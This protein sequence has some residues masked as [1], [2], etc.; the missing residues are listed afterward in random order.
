MNYADWSQWYDLF[1]STE[2]GEEVDFY[3]EEAIAANGP[4]L[5]IGVG[6]GRIAIPIA[7]RHIEVFGVDMS[8]EML[9]VA[10]AKASA[11]SPLTGS[12]TLAQADMRTLRLA[13]NDFALVAIPARTL[14]LATT[15]EDQV[16]TLCSAAR[17]LRPGGKLILNVF[18]PTPDLIFDDSGE[19]VL[20]GEVVDATTGKTFQLSAINRFDPE[21]QIN[22][23]TQIVEEVQVDG[24][25]MVVAELPVTLRYLFPHE[26]FSLLEETNLQVEAVYGWFDRSP[27]D[28]ECDEIIF[29]ATR[30]EESETLRTPGKSK[31]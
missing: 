7:L 13:K 11:A 17:H 8:P 25:R 4:V 23:A 24:S 3:L 31:E 26:I 14:L 29:V 2:S 20:I 6:T 15:P 30:L 12:L 5:E 18:N 10:E 28:E 27:F 21:T 22:N 19:P 16:D 9:A 1:Y